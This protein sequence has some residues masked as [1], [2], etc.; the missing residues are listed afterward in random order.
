M[1]QKI[2]NVLSGKSIGIRRIVQFFR[3]VVGCT[4]T[5]LSFYLQ[6]VSQSG[7]RVSKGDTV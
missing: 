6:K 5:N 1:L 3:V 4:G 2:N 7:L